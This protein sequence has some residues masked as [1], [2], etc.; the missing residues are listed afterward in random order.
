MR[1]LF[2]HP[3]FPGQ[4]LKLM[5]DLAQD[6][7]NEVVHLSHNSS[8]KGMKGVRK[9]QYRLEIKDTPLAHPFLVKMNEALHHGDAITRALLQ[10]RERGF[11]PDVIFSYAGH[12]QNFYL[13]DVYPDVPF[14]G[15]F[16]WFLHAHGG[17]YNFDPAWPLDFDRQRFIRV[18]NAH[19]L[20]DL[21]MADAGIVPTRWQQSRFPAEYR[22]KL[23]V[24]HDGVDTDYYSPQRMDTL[25]IGDL[26]LPLAG[27]ELLTY[28]TRGMEPFRGFPEFMRALAALQQ[29][30][31]NCH[32]VIVGSENIFY[33]RKPEGADNYKDALLKELAGQ[34]DLSRVHFTGWL[35]MK[36]YRDV[37]RAS[38]AHV[39][40]TY[41]YVLSWSMIEA[42]S[43]G[44]LVIG[45]RT[46]PVEE[47]IRDGDNGLLVDFPGHDALALTLERVLSAP[48]QFATLRARARQTALAFY[49]QRLLLPQQRA[50]VQH[51]A[52]R[53]G[54]PPRA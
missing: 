22:N 23:H 5:A 46:A 27:K 12:G 26:V 37:L 50:F 38:Q 18:H 28:S 17:E 36:E 34:L 20:M 25:R 44:C 32:A 2:I 24:V 54:R 1:Y 40:L 35:Q 43:T 52:T 10:L 39:Y 53:G 45:S 41:P 3:V 48:E 42:M 21:Q 51:F 19:M 6:P 31:P 15:Y 49:D 33:S 11:R 8:M 16:E 13:K 30:R 4:F 14:L 9:L 47:V 7:G 29:K